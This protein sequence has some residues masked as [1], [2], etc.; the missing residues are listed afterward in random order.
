MD[1]Q[2]VVF[3]FDGVCIDTE[4]AR[5]QSWQRIFDRYGFEL[6]LDEWVKNIGKAAWVSHPFDILQNLTGNP[7]DRMA[8][9]TLHR[10]YEVEIANAMPLRPG[11]ADRLIEAQALGIRCAI[12][13]SSSHHWVDGHLDRRGLLGYFT[14]IVCREDT[15]VHKP[16]PGP[17]LAALDRLG[18]ASSNA[19]AVEDSP[20]GIASAKAAGL[21]CIAVPCDLTR[22]MDLGAADRLVQSLEEVTLG[23]IA[24]STGASRGG[25]S[26]AGH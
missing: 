11:F 12:A 25:I 18:A 9:E 1:L 3:D 4:T 17:Y 15:G 23:E 14:T 10:E 5:L 13:S 8:L 16:D 7:L 21:Y 19:I 20:A 6:P 26:A 24:G 22:N 2:A